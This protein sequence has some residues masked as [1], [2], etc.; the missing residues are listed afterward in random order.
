MGPFARAT[1]PPL[2]VTDP[3]AWRG[4]CREIEDIGALPWEIVLEAM[5]VRPELTDRTPGDD[6]LWF[7]W[8]FGLRHT[9]STIHGGR[10][11][12]T[13]EGARFGRPV[14][15]RQ[16]PDAGSSERGAY[17]SWVR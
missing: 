7:V 4:R 17:V 9:G 2:D 3:A 12:H 15:L 1:R 14:Q 10:R 16:G 8:P 11:T 6:L 13:F 5:K